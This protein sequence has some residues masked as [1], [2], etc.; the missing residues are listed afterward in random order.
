MDGWGNVLFVLYGLPPAIVLAGALMAKLVARL[1]DK[2]L[3][4]WPALGIGVVVLVAS[5][6]AYAQYL[7]RTD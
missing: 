7:M 5:F 4:W 2:R 3:G 6:V 1:L